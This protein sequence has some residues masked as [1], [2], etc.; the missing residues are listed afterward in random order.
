MGK[1][2]AVFIL[3]LSLLMVMAFWVGG[4]EPEPEPEPEPDEEEVSEG[5]EITKI[6]IAVSSARGDLGWGQTVYE[7]VR[8]FEDANP[9]IEVFFQ[10]AVAYADHYDIASDFVDMGCELILGLGYEYIDTWA[11]VA[12]E[13]EDRYFAVSCAPHPGSEGYPPNLASGYFREEQAGYLLGVIAAMMTETGQVGYFSGGDIPCAVKP[14]NMY[15]L[16][17]YETDPDVEVLYAWS[18]SW[19]DPS[20]EM[21]TADGLYDMGCDIVFALWNCLGVVDVAQERDRYMIGSHMKIP[22]GEDV[23]LADYHADVDLLLEFFVNHVE[24][25]TFEP[26]V[27][28][29]GVEGGFTDAIINE[30]LLPDE[31][32]QRVEELKEKMI[33]GELEIPKL[34]GVMPEN[35]PEEPVDD[36][37]EY[38]EP[39][40]ENIY[41]D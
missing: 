19:A 20:L 15:R 24:E 2:I 12:W 31:V 26:K 28:E 9:D 27:Y 39:E 34:I 3:S 25:G 37:D 7:A 5:T 14:L 38:L 17:A 32:I 22:I 10:D 6:G 36:L 21:E 40:Y 13:N 16:G 23:V 30:A 4:C 35:W 33:T 41:I 29:F 1:K 18:G 11:E 8:D